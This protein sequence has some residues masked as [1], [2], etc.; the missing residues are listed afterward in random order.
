M[1]NFILLSIIPVVVYSHL[2]KFFHIIIFIFLAI[3][4]YMVFEDIFIQ[5]SLLGVVTLN[6]EFKEDNK[7]LHKED[8]GLDP[9][10]VTGF[11]DGESC[12]V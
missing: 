10:Y 12:L 11:S 2:H 4:S 1:D 9:H 3:E 8:S 5:F 7:S 6:N